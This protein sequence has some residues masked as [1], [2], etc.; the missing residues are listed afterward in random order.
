MQQPLLSTSLIMPG[1]EFA[2]NDPEEINELLGNRVDLIIDGGVCGLEPTTVVDL[3]EDQAEVIRY[4]KG[5]VS[6][7]GS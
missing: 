6:P 3:I 4:G 7:L 2:L 5:D 1:E